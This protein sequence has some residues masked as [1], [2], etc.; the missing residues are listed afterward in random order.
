MT[1]NEFKKIVKEAAR[2][3]FQEELKEILLEAIR[4]PKATIVESSP[5][6]NNVNNSGNHIQQPSYTSTLTTEDKQNMRQNYLSIINETANDVY[7]PNKSFNPIGV[8]PINGD[9]PEGELDMSQIMNLMG[10]K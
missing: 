10:K 3:V 8:D 9:L 7:N 4:S 1:T 6:I 2:E 5:Y